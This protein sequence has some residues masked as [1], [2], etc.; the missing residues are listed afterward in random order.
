[1]AVTHTAEKGLEQQQSAVANPVYVMS[2]TVDMAAGNFA[3]AIVNTDILQCLSIPAGV[4]VIA[5]FTEVITATDTA[6]AGTL[7]DGAGANSWD[8]AVDL[9]GTAGV[10]TFSTP[11]TD[12]YATTGKF[13]ATADTIDIVMDQAVTITTGVVKVS[14]LCIDVARSYA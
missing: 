10:V 11:G 1:M 12:A 8:A 3:T 9:D 7:G 4:F 5:V 13:Y 14:A 6:A 2:N